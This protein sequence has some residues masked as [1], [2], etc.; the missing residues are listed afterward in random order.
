MA[1]IKYILFFI[2][3]VLPLSLGGCGL[4]LPSTPAGDF[5]LAF[6]LPESGDPVEETGEACFTEESVFESIPG[7][8]GHHAATITAFS[9]G[10]LLA[11]WYSYSGEF[12]LDGSAIYLSRRPAG[13]AVWQPPQLH[14]DREHGDGNPVLYSEGDNVWLFQ[15]VVPYGWSTAHIEF[16]RSTDRG[17]TWTEPAKLS[18]AIGSNT[19]YPPVRLA[20]GQLLLPAYDEIFQRSLFFVSTDGIRWSYRSGVSSSPGNIQPSVAVL[21]DGSWR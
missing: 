18:W 8:I 1:P 12:E 11:G 5:G 2:S 15:A 19:R 6:N 20:D 7:L 17:V 9:D 14:I 3:A 10:E 13:S 16:Q 4:V 21:T